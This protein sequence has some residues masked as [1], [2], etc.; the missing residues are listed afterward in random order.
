MKTRKIFVFIAV[1]FTVLAMVNFAFAQNRGEVKVTSEGVQYHAACDKAGGFSVEF[2][3]G[4]VLEHGDQI[5]I[6]LNYTSPSQQVVLCRNIDFV[7]SNG[8]AD[9]DGGSG[10][11]TTDLDGDGTNDDLNIPTSDSPVIM[12]DITNA[13]NFFST[14]GGVF[15]H[16]YGTN[17]QGRIYIDVI[18]E[19]QGDDVCTDD[20]DGDCTDGDTGDV[21]TDNNGDGDCDDV[22]DVCTDDGD[23]DCTD[24]DA[25]DVCT[26]NNADG[27]CVDSIS[28]IRVGSDSDDTLTIAFFDQRINS[29]DFAT[30]GIYIDEDDDDE[31]DDSAGLENTLCINASSWDS[32]TISA[33]M[34]SRNDK[35]SFIPS[36]PQIAHIIAAT[37]ITAFSCKSGSGNIEMEAS[38]T[39]SAGNCTFDSD[40]GDGYCDTD[41]ENRLVIRN[42][43]KYDMNIQYQV[44]LRIMVNGVYGENGVYFSNDAVS[45]GRYVSSTE[46]CDG[47][48]AASVGTESYKRADGSDATPMVTN[49]TCSSIAASRRA[50]YMI[51]NGVSM[52]DDTNYQYLYIDIPAFNYDPSV[53]S[54]N[55]KVE[56]EYTLMKAPCGELIKETHYIG[57]FGCTASKSTTLLYPYFTYMDD[58]PIIDDYW[59]GIVVTNLGTTAGTATLTIYERDGDVGS[60][61]TP[62]IAP[63]GMFVNV[64]YNIL[65]LVSKISG[66]G[67]MGDERCYVVVCTD[68]KAHGFAMLGNQ[69]TGESMGYLPVRNAEDDE[70]LCP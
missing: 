31:Y 68:F 54:E 12:H 17:G 63:S 25:G 8:V 16:V 15:F 14:G 47:S 41:W 23:G 49:S 33:N 20:G 2:D 1:V 22:A 39:Q 51:T 13:N 70:D 44:E 65:P 3:A 30:N 58:D 40:T 34:D 38:T 35:F 42:A 4:T 19:I 32:P 9:L 60:Y 21:C 52:F 66:S 57:T 10:G 50:T 43:N 48:T 7:I 59:D 61:T 5:T 6:D 69:A 29:T 46:A 27:D 64:L 18:G 11:W 37:T 28:S 55:D 24:G 36:N 53:V 56:V 67:T 26:D 62:S 45:Y